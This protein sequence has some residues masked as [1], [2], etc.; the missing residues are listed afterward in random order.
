MK[1]L[2]LLMMLLML[3][4]SA[5]MAQN[6]PFITKIYDFLPA[7][8]QF[9]NSIPEWEEGVSKDSVIR[10]AEKLICGY[11]NSDGNVVICVSIIQLRH[12]LKGSHTSFSDEGKLVYWRNIVTP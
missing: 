6:K 12:K 9:V 3:N 11:Y 2:I 7:P 8:G 5:F 4:I 10:A 1:R